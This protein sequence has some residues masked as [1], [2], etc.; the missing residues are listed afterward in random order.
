MNSIILLNRSLF[1]ILL[2]PFFTSAQVGINT[3]TP[4]PN[5][6]LDVN[7]RIVIQDLSRTGTG[8][9][10]VKIL[11]IEQDGT[12]IQA[13]V[14]ADLI[15]E[16]NNNTLTISNNNNNNTTTTNEKIV[17]IN[18]SFGTKNNWD[19]D[20]DGGNSDAT[21]FIIHK[22]SGGNELK[23]RGIKGGTD[24]RKIR[25]INDSGKKIKFEEDKNEA[26]FGNKIYIFTSENEMS[27]YGSCELIY[28]TAISD[29]GGHWNLIQLDKI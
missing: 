6:A 4:N 28:S 3:T 27:T 24:G 19:L 17:L 15:S 29:D 11:L 22:D 13:S 21:V 2:V 1:L 16:D 18:E 7:G 20:L 5:S 12:L 14:D 8:I 25:I 23:I 9:S 10:G 26:S